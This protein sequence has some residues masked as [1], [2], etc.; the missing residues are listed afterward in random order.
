[1]NSAARTLMRHRLWV[2]RDSAGEDPIDGGGAAPDWDPHLSAVACH[3]WYESDNEI[4]DGEKQA[5]L[6]GW[7]AIVPVGTDVTEKDRIS[8][9][10]TRLGSV[11]FTGPAEVTGVGRR[12]DHLVL[13]LEEVG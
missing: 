2:E 3:W 6:E 5:V 1:M 10:E 12:A 7:K 9:V 11:I 4:I 8:R 13:T